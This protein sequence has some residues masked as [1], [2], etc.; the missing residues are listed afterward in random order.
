MIAR[1]AAKTDFGSSLAK[2]KLDRS[3]EPFGVKTMKRSAST[4]AP[5]ISGPAPT[6]KFPICANI[7]H[8]WYEYFTKP[9]LPVSRSGENREMWLIFFKNRSA[10]ITWPNSWTGV[11]IQAVKSTPPQPMV[12]WYK[13][14]VAVLIRSSKYPNTKKE[15][16]MPIIWRKVF[17][18]A[19]RKFS[20][21]GNFMCS[22]YQNIFVSG[23][24]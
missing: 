5:E 11:P 18:P 7:F 23:N 21:P 3:S 14:L 2:S 12:R 16:K 4:I 15:P 19:I 20:G 10:N 9:R 17:F 13:L 1:I 22:L 8:L 24:N 6:K